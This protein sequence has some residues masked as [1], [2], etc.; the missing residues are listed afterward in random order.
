M[1]KCKR[2]NI[3]ELVLIMKKNVDEAEQFNDF[4][5]GLVRHCDKDYLL[6]VLK[7]LCDA[8]EYN[9]ERYDQ[10]YVLN[11]N[12]VDDP[13]ELKQLIKYIRGGIIAW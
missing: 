2:K 3:A 5:E 6:L 1:K 11:S 12:I 4:I 8:V 7:Q 10:G 13:E 9:L